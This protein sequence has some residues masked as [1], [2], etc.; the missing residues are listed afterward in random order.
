MT[1]V[2]SIYESIR[3]GIGTLPDDP[4]SG[5]RKPES[6]MIRRVDLAD[7]ETLEKFATFYNASGQLSWQLNAARLR[8]KLGATGIAYALFSSDGDVLGTIA[9]KESHI[10]GLRGAEVGYY[11]VDEA[12]RTYGNAKALYKSV[13][14]HAKE[15]DFVFSSTNVNNHT[16]N[17]LSDYMGEFKKIFTAK[18]PYSS[19]QL[20]YW[21]CVENNGSVAM[22]KV[23]EVLTAEFAQ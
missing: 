17:K 20:H 13:V 8:Q 10:G 23:I 19:N 4:T 16:I 11:M 7:T 5:G 6:L 14:A 9:L 21:L 12:N 3:N 15:F 1:G 22:Q 2:R 18:S